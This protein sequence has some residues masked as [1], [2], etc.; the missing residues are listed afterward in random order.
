MIQN[1]AIIQRFKIKQLFCSTLP[2]NIDGFELAIPKLSGK[3]SYL[4]PN[5]FLEECLKFQTSW[6]WQWHY[7]MNI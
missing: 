5:V 7:K 2:T 4:I 3:T 6:Q 1:P